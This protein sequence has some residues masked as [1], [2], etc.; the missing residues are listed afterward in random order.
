[1]GLT[2]LFLFLRASRLA[3]YSRTGAS[4]SAFIWSRV[5]NCGSRLA[6][7]GRVTPF[8]GDDSTSPRRMRNL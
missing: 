4:S 2:G 3:S 7:L 5:R 8:T 1:M 6:G